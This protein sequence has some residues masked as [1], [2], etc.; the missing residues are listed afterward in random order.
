MISV[1]ENFA[2]GIDDPDPQRKALM[3]EFFIE[4]NQFMST[5]HGYKKFMC[6]PWVCK[7]DANCEKFSLTLVYNHDNSVSISKI[8]FKEKRNGHGAALIEV[9]DNVSHKYKIPFIEFVSVSTEPMQSFVQ[10]F[11]FT[12]REPEYTF[13]ETP[14]ILSNW[15]RKSPFGLNMENKNG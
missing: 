1:P 14:S 11:G 7:V 3:V 6:E 13:D 8:G 9:L 5:R 12:K 15:F 2:D 4:L 10:K